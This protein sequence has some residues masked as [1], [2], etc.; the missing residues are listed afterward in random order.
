MNRSQKKRSQ[1]QVTVEEK[2]IKTICWDRKIDSLGQKNKQ[3]RNPPHRRQVEKQLRQK[4]KSVTDRCVLLLQYRWKDKWQIWWGYKSLYLF[5]QIIRQEN[6]QSPICT[7]IPLGCLQITSQHRE[8]MQV[9]QLRSW[10]QEHSR[11]VFET[12]YRTP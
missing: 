9:T 4:D 11:L 1:N 8:P 2:L 12:I 5:F 10:K 6:R 7:D 3:R